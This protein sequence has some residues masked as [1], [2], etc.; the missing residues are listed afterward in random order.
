MVYL[1][2]CQASRERNKQVLVGMDSVPKYSNLTSINRLPSRV[3][4]RLSLPK[5]GIPK[6]QDLGVWNQVKPGQI[7]TW[8]SS[9]VVL[10]RCSKFSRTQETKVSIDL[11]YTSI[12]T[13]R[14]LEPAEG[15]VLFCS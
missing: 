15:Q 7:R 10:R 9:V 13:M 1:A 2:H 11:F 6:V 8:L 12:S 5:I 3:P 4:S 14:C